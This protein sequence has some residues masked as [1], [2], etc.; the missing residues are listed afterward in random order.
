MVVTDHINAA[1]AAFKYAGFVPVRVLT[2]AKFSGPSG[3]NL[4]QCLASG[5]CKY[6]HIHPPLMSDVRPYEVAFWSQCELY[7]TEATASSTLMIINCPVV[8]D[9]APYHYQAF[10]HQ[11][12]GR[13]HTTPHR[14]CHWGI[15]R[16]GLS[17]SNV[18][19]L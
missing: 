3:T 15:K 11:N 19:Y 9:P 6:V 17:S 18:Q 12:I 4:L 14:W 1:S 5:G 2:P 13:L 7:L 10:V 8:Q 16:D